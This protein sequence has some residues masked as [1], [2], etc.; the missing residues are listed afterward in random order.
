MVILLETFIAYTTQPD[1]SPIG[2]PLCPVRAEKAKFCPFSAIL[3]AKEIAMDSKIGALIG[4]DSAPIKRETD[5]A[6]TANAV[7]VF[8]RYSWDSDAHKQRVLAVAQ[9]LRNDGVDAWLD[10]FTT[11]PA[12]GWPRWMENE[13]ARAQFV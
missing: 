11:F 5:V 1:M 10:R 3:V 6:A 9:R 7:R 4:A 8:L 13:I 2:D 12:E